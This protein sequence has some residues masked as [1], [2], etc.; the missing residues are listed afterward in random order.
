MNSQNINEYN[1]PGRKSP[2]QLR[3]QV[4]QDIR[5]VR[6]DLDEIKHRLTPGQIIDDAIF[7]R[8]VNNSPADTYTLLRQNPIGTSLLTLGTIMLMEDDRTHRTYESMAWDTAHDV[9]VRVDGVIDNTKSKVEKVQAKVGKVSDS[10]NSY[11]P[12]KDEGPGFAPNKYDIAKA[13]VSGAKDAISSVGH[14]LREGLDSTKQGISSVSHS[15]KE[16]IDSTKESL[17]SSVESAKEGLDSASR[18]IKGKIDHASEELQESADKFA[19]SPGVTGPGFEGY[20]DTKEELAS[21]SESLKSVARENIESAKSATR[22]GL[23][24]LKES[25]REGFDSLK[26]KSKEVYETASHLDPLTYM[27]LGAGLGTLTGA[28]LPVFEAEREKVD[29]VLEEKMETFK[30]E[31]ESAINESINT[32]KNE[33][34]GGVTDLN[35]N[36]F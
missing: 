12:H 3:D 9:K 11:L 24:S 32:L 35:L 26:S 17:S 1:S 4:M 25:S 21:A 29:E 36:I 15:I 30:K 20:Q 34:I 8:R 7:Y 19:S 31:L 10:I 2:K 6:E 14:S 28:S 16:G 18:K 27:V 13:K 5:R 33:F 22:E 23:D